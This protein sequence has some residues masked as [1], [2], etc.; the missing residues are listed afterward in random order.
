LR[1][2][3]GRCDW[4]GQAQIPEK[5]NHYCQTVCGQMLNRALGKKDRSIMQSSTQCK[6]QIN[7]F[8]LPSDEKGFYFFKFPLLDNALLAQSFS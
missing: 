8:L 6:V 7:K 5:I 3:A 4:P 2:P 1:G